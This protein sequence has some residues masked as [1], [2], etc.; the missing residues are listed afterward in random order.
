V[1]LE[2]TADLIGAGLAL[3]GLVVHELSGSAAADALA[4]MA[5]GALL[6]YM[7]T[8]L[9]SRN[10]ELLTNR[11]VPERYTERLSQMILADDAVLS[12]PLLQAVYLGPREV[13]VTGEICLADGLDTAGVADVIGRVRDVVTRTYPQVSHLFLTPVR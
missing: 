13:L 3:V 11:A 9:A 10:R 12:V 6:V 2:D 7:A 5:I 4:S 1:Y 8:R